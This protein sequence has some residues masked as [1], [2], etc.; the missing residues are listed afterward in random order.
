MV[1]FDCDFVNSKEAS[2]IRHQ[3]LGVGRQASGSF[4]GLIRLIG[5]IS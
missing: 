5:L 4:I 3:A 1:V 2:G